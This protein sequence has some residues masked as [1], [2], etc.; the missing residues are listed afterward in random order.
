[1]LSSVLW[2]A[3]GLVLLVVGAELLVR[4]ASRLAMRFGISPLVVGLTVVAF[5]TSAPELAVSLDAASRGSAAI[6]VGNVL[7]SNVFNVLA[8]LGLSALC[9]PLVVHRR[10]VQIDAPLVLAATLAAWALAADG[11][12]V[13]WEG[14]LLFAGVV[15]YT[16]FQVRAGRAESAAEPEP[17]ERPSG[18][19]ARDVVL[20]LAGLGL[21]VLGAR[22]LVAGASDVA[23]TLG[24]S[25]LVIGLTIVAGGTSLPELATSV[26]AALRGQRDIAVGNVI[27]SNVFNLLCVLGGSALLAPAPI[28]I[29]VQALAFDFPVTA[30][31]ALACLP[32]LFSG[33]TITRWEGA[34]FVAYYVVYTAWLVLAARGSTALPGLATAVTWFALPFTA[35]TLVVGSWRWW[36]RP[37]A[38]R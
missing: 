10:I 18:N 2:I 20:V 14:A 23:R 37:R 35:A 28:E 38:Q 17:V 4:G 5:G 22:W 30:A 27:G 33:H 21:L 31:V 9:A 34:L 3:L 25:E 24:L 1:M 7:G 36:R 15:A 29:P 6:A 12:L 19:R 11:R 16:H 8:V 26:I 13:R 32:V